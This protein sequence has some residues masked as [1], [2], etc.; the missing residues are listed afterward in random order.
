MQERI[1]TTSVSKLLCSGQKE[2]RYWKSCSQ[3]FSQYR[4]DLHSLPIRLV[5]GI[6]EQIFD[7]VLRDHL[8]T[9]HHEETETREDPFVRVSGQN[10][11]DFLT[12]FVTEI[13]GFESYL[14]C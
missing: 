12:K 9:A 1:L 2:I 10:F 6:H 8:N 13:T 5:G 14:Y 11:F 4:K 3:Y 7:C